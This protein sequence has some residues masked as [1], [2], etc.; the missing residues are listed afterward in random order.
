M[1]RDAI[2][3]D[4]PE[5]VK[6]YYNTLTILAVKQNSDKNSLETIGFI[7]NEKKKLEAIMPELRK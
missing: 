5:Q 7:I 2:P 1:A 3:F 6:D 4:K